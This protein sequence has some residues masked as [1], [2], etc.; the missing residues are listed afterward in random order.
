M[1]TMAEALA[2]HQWYDATN[3]REDP[4]IGCTGC[5]D[6]FGSEDALDDGTFAT[7]Q[8]A[9]LAKAGYGNKADAWD[10][11]HETGLWNGPE[12]AGDNPYRGAGHE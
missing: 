3:D 5:D 6:W 2:K 9:E 1:S 11:G 8:A 10:E 4:A 12:S 7:H